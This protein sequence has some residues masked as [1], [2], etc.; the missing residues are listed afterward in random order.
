MG[1]PLTAGQLHYSLYHKVVFWVV[2]FRKLVTFSLKIRR[3]P[4]A[5][6]HQYHIVAVR[7]LHK[8]VLK[9]DVTSRIYCYDGNDA[10]SLV[11]QFP[12]S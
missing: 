1:K 3:I 7:I 8:H 6:I 10:I 9:L 12:C 11:V 4:I 5:I 2:I